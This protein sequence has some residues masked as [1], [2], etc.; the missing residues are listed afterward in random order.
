MPTRKGIYR[1]IKQK[2]P[3]FGIHAWWQAGT[4]MFS[5]LSQSP[6][7]LSLGLAVCSEGIS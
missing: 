6:P 1:F 7:A 4:E 3:G 5:A 2:S